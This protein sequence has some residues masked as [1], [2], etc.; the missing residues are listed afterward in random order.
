[1]RTPSVLSSEKR[2]YICGS[3]ACLERHHIFGGAYR[4][5]SDR[6]GLW[7]YLCHDCHNEPPNGV[8]HNRA[9]MDA[10]RA[11]A[12]RAYIEQNGIDV[13]EFIRRYGRNYL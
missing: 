12:E 5:K 3:F 8:H 7:V 6:E 9:N 13:S 10:L 11:E 1:M 4:K 2:C